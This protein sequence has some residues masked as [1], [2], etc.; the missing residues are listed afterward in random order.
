MAPRPQQFT[1][2]PLRNRIRIELSAHPSDVWALV[3]DLSR[4]PEYS[5][6]LDKVEAM[7][8]PD[9]ACTEY[10][11]VFKPQV[12][13]GETIQ[14][15][16]TMRWYAAESG[17][18]SMPDEPNAFGLRSCLTLVTLE[19]GEARTVLVWDEYYDHDD[20]DGSK[21]AFDQ[22]LADIGDNLIGRFGGRVVERFMEG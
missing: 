22:A 2:S 9:G 8:D 14:H 13:G 12:E 16:E 10:V 5:L 1:S 20:L 6:G 3:G 15:R 11:C 4:Y 18:A 21:A 7:L 17:Y 19:P